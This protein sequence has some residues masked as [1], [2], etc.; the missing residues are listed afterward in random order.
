MDGHVDAIVTHWWSPEGV[1]LTPPLLVREVDAAGPLISVPDLRGGLLASWQEDRRKQGWARVVQPLDGAGQP[2]P[3]QPA[4]ALDPDLGGF[5]TGSLGNAPWGAVLATG[6]QRVALRLGREG[7]SL[8]AAFPFSTSTQSISG[9]M[10]AGLPDG[11]F[12][13]AWRL[14]NPEEGQPTSWARFFA[15]DG[16]PVGPEFPIADI[17]DVTRLKWSPRGELVA[18]GSVNKQW[19]SEIWLQRVGLDG[20]LIGGPVLVYTAQRLTS[21]DLGISPAGDVLTV[22]GERFFNREILS[23]RP[24]RFDGGP[25]GPSVTLWDA[26]V[27]PSI[28][29]VRASGLSRRLHAGR[30]FV[31]S[32]NYSVRGFGEM[33]SLCEDTLASCGNGEVD[34]ACEQC[35]EGAANADAVPDACRTTCTLPRCGDDVLDSGEACD[36]GNIESCDGCSGSCEL[37]PGA[38]CGDGIVSDL[39]GEGC[40]DGNL[41]VGDGCSPGCT[42]ERIVGKSKASSCILEFVVNN[43]TNFPYLDRRGSISREQ[44]CNENDPRCD[45]DGGVAGSCTFQVRACVNNT[46]IPDCAPGRLDAVEIRSPRPNQTEAYAALSSQLLALVGSTETNRCTDVVNLTLPLRGKPPKAKGKMNLKVFSFSEGRR[47]KDRVRL[48][49][50]S[51]SKPEQPARFTEVWDKV[52]SRGCAMCHNPDQHCCDFLDFTTVGDAFT[53]LQGVGREECLGQPRVVPGN[54]EASLLYKKLVDPDVCGVR[55][56]ARILFPEDFEDCRLDACLGAEETEL[57]RRWINSG[58]KLN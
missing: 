53:T 28:S 13:I 48:T 10:V 21:L 4:L 31:T 7:G 51:S 2:R 3:Q 52:L 16:I 33:I 43:P 15:A 29:N 5:A 27:G 30:G 19:G 49:C 18:L 17:F 36:D 20:S 8:G 22:W 32:W 41:L 42:L 11:S 50:M 55:M 1:A 47:D 9:P 24:Y 25:M 44:S 38:I 35:D 40:D 34:H 39:C 12:V 6:S 56:P 46:N 23:A 26:G 45:L 58:A 57:V 14:R 37:E 54:A